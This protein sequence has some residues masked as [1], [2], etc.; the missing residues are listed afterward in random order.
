MGEEKILVLC[1]NSFGLRNQNVPA[2]GLVG[3]L[4]HS[5]DYPKESR[6]GEAT[7]GIIGLQICELNDRR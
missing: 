6:G 4:R 5:A 7:D 2:C 3:N 1:E